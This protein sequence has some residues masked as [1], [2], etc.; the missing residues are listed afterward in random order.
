MRP[1]YAEAHNNLAIVLTKEGGFDEAIA[2]YHRALEIRKEYPEAHNNLGIALM[3][4]GQT[5][6]ALAEFDKALELRQEYPDVRMNRSLTYLIVGDFERGWR[7][8][9]N[10][11]K[12]KEFKPR[13]FVQPRWNGEPLE[14]K[15]ILLHTEQGI[16]DTLQFVRYARLVKERGGVVLIGATKPLQRILRLCPYLDGIFLEG[17]ELP[18]FDVQLPLMSLPYVFGTHA[19]TIPAGEPYL[20]ADPG[21]ITRWRKELSYI[22]AFKVGINW[23]GNPKFRGDYRRSI[24]L[25]HFGEL[26][27]VPGVRLISLQKGF[28]T[29]QLK[30]ARFSVTELGGQ[31]DEAAGPFMDTAAVLK[32]LDL[33]VTSDTALA[34]LAGGLGVPVWLAL[35]YAPDWRWQLSRSDCPWYPNMR[36]FRQAQF[37][38]WSPVFEKIAKALRKVVSQKRRN[39]SYRVPLSRG[40]LLDRLTMARC[41][42]PCH[43]GRPQRTPSKAR[44]P[45]RNVRPAD[46]KSDGCSVGGRVGS[47]ERIAGRR[48]C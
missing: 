22:D 1:D 46:G 38:D 33:F 21:L 12:C 43:P 20:F 32:N 6:E 3:E 26:A 15:R 8:Y 42:A 9:E 30:D 47:C 36:L 7:E 2:E 34:H 45:G 5:G 31:V 41:A 13:G 39:G 48:A 18:E 24:P 29:E 35:P 4:C 25:A 23:Q 16:G 10:R 14:G 37:D 44:L 40:E 11:W 27:T 19:E 28:G 17:A